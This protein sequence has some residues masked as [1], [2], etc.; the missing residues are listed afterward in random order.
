MIM[1][2]ISAVPYLTNMS[3]CTL[4]GVQLMHSLCMGEICSLDLFTNPWFVNLNI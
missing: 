3:E 4:L 2:V 1:A